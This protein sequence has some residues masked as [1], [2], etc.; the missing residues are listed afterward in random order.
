MNPRNPSNYEVIRAQFGSHA[1]KQ[2]ALSLLIH[3]SALP[4]TDWYQRDQG[5]FRSGVMRPI[6]PWSERARKA[7][8]FTAWR[9]F[10]QSLTESLLLLQVGPLMT[11]DDASLAASNFSL[12][13]LL[14]STKV[15]VK[16]VQEHEVF[17]DS[18]PEVSS[19]R[20][21]LRETEGFA[22]HRFIR[23][24]VASVGSVF[25]YSSLSQLDEPPTAEEIL[26]LVSPQ[27]LK[28]KA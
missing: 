3:A 8:N 9:A 16:L 14:V 1:K 25:L 13:N 12:D 4:G 24:M 5:L 20:I 10:G 27:V 26:S 19:A 7:G 6:T 17:G 18:I 15:R 11:L 22:G 23:I 21:F 28:L 2:E